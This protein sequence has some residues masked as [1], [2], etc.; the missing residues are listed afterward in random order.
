MPLTW[1]SY[2]YWDEK[3]ME[4]T[5]MGLYRVSGLGSSSE[6]MYGSFWPMLPGRCLSS[7]RPAP[8]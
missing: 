5:I 4:I 8:F 3:K 2:N 6:F 1:E 7:K